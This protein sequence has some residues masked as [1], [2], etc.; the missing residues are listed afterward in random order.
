MEVKKEYIPMMK[1][2]FRA[3]PQ[4]LFIK[5]TEGKYAFTTKVCD[6][7]NAEIRKVSIRVRHVIRRV[8]E[9]RM[10]FEVVDGKPSILQHTFDAEQQL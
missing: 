6:L 7:V 1:D 4:T 10:Q 9:M 2:V 3:L 5:D 8:A